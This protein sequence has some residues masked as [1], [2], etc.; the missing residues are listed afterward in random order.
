MK[1]FNKLFFFLFTTVS[2]FAQSPEKMSYQAVVRDANNTLLTNQEVGMQISILQNTITGTAVYIETQTAITNINGLISLVIGSGT[3]SYN[4]STIDWSAGPYFIKTATDPSGGSSYS[5]TGTSQIMSVPFA[6]YAKTSGSSQTNA[7]N[8]SNNTTDI[9]ANT[10]AI[11]DNITA[12]SDEITR[13]LDAEQANEIA[14][15]TIQTE[16]NIQNTSISLNAVKI[17]YPGDQDISGIAAN[18]SN[19]DLKA[20]LTGAAFTGAVV[21]KRYVLTAPTAIAATADTTIDLSA[22]NVITINLSADTTLTTSNADVGTYLIKL[23]QGVGNNNVYF[24]ETWK[25]PGGFTPTVTLTASK[26]DIVTLI[27]DGTNYY[28]AITQNF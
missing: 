26:T 14:I 5:I 9:N 23:V 16:Q 8:I 19:I 20:N 17:T 28:A 3:S 15:A 21:A 4:F 18:A 27:F 12:I 24:P 10:T 7:T 6:L 22:G 2:V 13:A 1:I 11:T 25:W